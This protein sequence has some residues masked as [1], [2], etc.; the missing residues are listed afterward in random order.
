MKV[1]LKT[2]KAIEKFHEKNEYY[3]SLGELSE[4][5]KTHKNTIWYHVKELEF[6]GYLKRNTKGR[7]ISILIPSRCYGKTKNCKH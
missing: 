5:T 2:L 4:A 6:R 1:F 7:I 3:P